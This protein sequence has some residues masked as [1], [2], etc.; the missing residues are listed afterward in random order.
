MTHVS[1]A[2]LSIE[3]Q[4]PCSLLVNS[5]MGMTKFAIYETMRSS[6][7]S[8]NSAATPCVRSSA[9]RSIWRPAFP[10]PPTEHP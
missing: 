8:Y 1:A 10:S 7:V 5:S 2:A 6:M 9:N 3:Y 4:D